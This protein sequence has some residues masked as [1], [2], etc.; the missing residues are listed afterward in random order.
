MGMM[1]YDGPELGPG[2]TRLKSLAQILLERVADYLCDAAADSGGKL[3]PAGIQASLDEFHRRA[4]PDI[5]DFYR[6]GAAACHSN[7]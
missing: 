3:D 7:G 4:D 6:T 2:P 1:D 5:T